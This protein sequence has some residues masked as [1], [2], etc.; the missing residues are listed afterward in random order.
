MTKLKYFQNYPATIKDQVLSLIESGKLKSY[1]KN[2]YPNP[3]HINSDKLL[4]Q[5]A[6]DLKKQYMRNTPQI[7]KVLYEKQKDL[8]NNALGTH[9]FVSRNHGGKLKSKH[10]IRIA[11]FL[12]EAPEEMLE[13]LVV[14][15]LAHFKEKDH[16][17]AFYKLC[18]YMQPD[19]HQV[20]FD[21]RLYLVLL[22]QGESL[23][24]N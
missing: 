18:Q 12:K 24:N 22:D 13:M 5:Y 20:E 19:Y 3:H 17:K 10:E 16:N 15:E 2:K 8:I 21:L 11:M 7:S 1:L 4:Y 6:N 14:H 9:S 23:F